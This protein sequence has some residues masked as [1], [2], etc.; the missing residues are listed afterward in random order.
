MLNPISFVKHAADLFDQRICRLSGHE[1]H[2][3]IEIIFEMAIEFQRTLLKL[4]HIADQEDGV[5]GEN[6][7]FH[8][9]P[10]LQFASPFASKW[11]FSN[12]ETI[13][14]EDLGNECG[15]VSEF[16]D[17]SNPQLSPQELPSY[18]TSA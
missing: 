2:G 14:K 8:R 1:R 10:R 16:V 9:G 13:Q 5:V 4:H 11:T 6:R 12:S 7:S 18:M 15:F 17:F 3:I